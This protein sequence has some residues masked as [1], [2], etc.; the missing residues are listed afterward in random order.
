M[1]MASDETRRRLLTAAAARVRASGY[2]GASVDGILGP[3]G[4]TKGAFYHHFP[5]K[6]ALGR[7]LVDRFSADLVSRLDGASTPEAALGAALSEAGTAIVDLCGEYGEGM[8]GMREALTRALS[9]WQ[10]RLEEAAGSPSRA[11]LLLAV[12][13]GASLLAK[14]LG[15]PS[16][17]A[18]LAA[19]VD[20][21]SS[22][23][24]EGLSYID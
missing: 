5:S 7:L 6:E 21:P 10:G 20:A 14:V 17:A 1:T 9:A 16:V 3:A 2:R 24:A 23:R 15:D 18:R 8:E 22:A 11:E 13:L 4:L 12:S 19:Q